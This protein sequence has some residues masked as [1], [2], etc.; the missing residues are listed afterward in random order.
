MDDSSAMR[1]HSVEDDDYL[2]VYEHSG[3]IRWEGQIHF[4]YQRNS[5]PK[6]EFLTRQL[7]F[8]RVM[9]GFQSNCDPE[10]WALMFFEQLPATLLKK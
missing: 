9:H 7:A 6:P 2:T 5:S 3:V 8:G 1:V 10:D 4:E